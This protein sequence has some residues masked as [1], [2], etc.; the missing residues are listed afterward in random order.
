MMKK[1]MSYDSGK[2][3]AKK[4]SMSLPDYLKQISKRNLDIAAAK[5]GMTSESRRELAKLI[6]G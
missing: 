5:S 2:I 4:S 3:P 6:W 1:S